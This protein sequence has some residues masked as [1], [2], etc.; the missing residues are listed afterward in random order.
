MLP[1][2]CP[3]IPIT[4]RLFLSVEILWSL[5][6]FSALGKLVLAAIE[7]GTPYIKADSPDSLSTRLPTC[8]SRQDAVE[9][10]QEPQGV[11]TYKRSLYGQ[12]AVR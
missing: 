4:P 7:K 10:F 1:K 12:L 2:P 6:A 8:S 9:V 5:A 11:P 3:L